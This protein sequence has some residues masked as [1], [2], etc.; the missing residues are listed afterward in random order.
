MAC[1][2]IA[3]RK[4]CRPVLLLTLLAF[5]AIQL[6]SPGDAQQP[7]PPQGRGGLPIAPPLRGPLPAAADEFVTVGDIA[8]RFREVGAGDPVVV[9]HGWSRTLDDWST[10]A[11]ALAPT[12]RVIAMDVRGFG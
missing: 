6:P 7:Q 10:V 12:H 8:I 11:E 4:P 9:L 1:L 5:M 3:A 2:S